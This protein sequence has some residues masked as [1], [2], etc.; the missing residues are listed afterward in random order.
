MVSLTFEL[1]TAVLIISATDG[2]LDILCVLLY[3]KFFL[4]L[5]KHYAVKTCGSREE[6]SR[7]VCIRDCADTTS[8]LGSV[9]KKKPSYLG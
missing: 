1:T 5:I 8:S 2:R 4:S 9:D 3:M 7:P 6:P